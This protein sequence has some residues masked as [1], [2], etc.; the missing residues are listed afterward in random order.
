[1]VSYFKVVMGAA[2]LIA[3]LTGCSCMYKDDTCVV[4]GV[5]GIEMVNFPLAS[6]DSISIEGFQK[7]S[8][9]TVR[10][11][12]VF[13]SAENYNQTNPY[14]HFQPSFDFN[15]DYLVTLLS[16]GTGNQYRITDCVIGQTECKSCALDK[17]E[18]HDVLEGYS[19]NG[20]KFDGKSIKI[21]W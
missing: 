4:I 5:G 14:L 20:Q 2:V 21:T 7:G 15:K 10:T 17:P 9:F 1:M 13:T 3:G 16:K 18:H 11:D 8:G 6:V 19:V 12:S